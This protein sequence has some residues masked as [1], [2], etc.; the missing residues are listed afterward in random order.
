M[1]FSSTEIEDNLIYLCPLCGRAEKNTPLKGVL[2]VE[3]DYKLMKKKISKEKFLKNSPGKFWKYPFLWPINKYPS[4]KI[5]LRLQLSQSPILTYDIDDKQIQFFDDTRN[6]TLS[7]KDRAS[8]VVALKA[9][10]LGIKEISAASTGN[11][12][13]SIAG[14]CARLGLKTHI[15]VPA[16]IPVSKRIQIQSYGA[17]IYL[18]NGTYD[19]AF[20][21]CLE[22]S[23]EKKIYNRNTA[24]NPLTIEG[25]KWAAIDIFLQ[26]QGKL[27]DFIFVPVGDGVVI[28]GLFKGFYD[29]KKLGWI[30]KYPRLI[31]VQAE[32]SDGLVRFL[33]RGEYEFR[34]ATTVADSISASAP[35]NLYMAANVINKTNGKAL[36]V[37]DKEILSAQSFISKI[38]GL[39]VEPSSAA[40][41]A[42]YKK[43]ISTNQISPK[44]KILLMMTGN[45][46]KDTDTVI[47]T[48]PEPSVLSS[49]QIKEIFRAQ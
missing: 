15:F 48:L 16:A 33:D 35:R 26:S 25:K 28:S 49:N 5:L 14:I 41:F 17:N 43:F 22:I 20:D 7:Y 6:P 18:V 46:L 10:E 36:S 31:G 39:F 24:F 32:G 8:T 44:A 30:K 1:R 19:D 3:Y 2:T 40:T 21:L 34:I 12:G 42:G 45:G 4:E 29:L 13:S 38:T 23:S 27:P 37:S 47:K 11:A 9:L